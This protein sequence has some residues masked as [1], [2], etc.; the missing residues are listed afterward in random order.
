MNGND[1]EE[2]RIEAMLRDSYGE[3]KP[4]DSWA[5]LRGRIDRRIEN[6][7]LPGVSALQ[8]SRSIAFWRRTALALAAC[9]L[10]A[11]GLLIYA[12]G[13]VQGGRV[14]GPLTKPI[15]TGLFSQAQL[16]QLKETFSNVR[17]LFE[18]QSAWIVVGSG[19]D[20]EIGVE[21]IGRTWDASK[22]VVVRLAVN[23]EKEN[24]AP[25]FFDVVTFP[26]QRADFQLPLADS[27]PVKVSLRP[28][29]KDKALAVEIR[30]QV[31]GRAKSE[32]T[33]T[34]DDNVFTSLVRL[35]SDGDWVTINGIARSVS[36]I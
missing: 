29:V 34:V 1:R 9:L 16:D 13:F 27:S 22:I 5:A 21:Q 12:L 25:R 4:A 3:I 7:K 30:A 24:T 19:N 35:P 18:E 11:I 32:T 15:N 33:T 36:S 10:I 6:A 14:D 8:G 28:L 23:L 17:Q 26:N 31:N 20:A 2:N